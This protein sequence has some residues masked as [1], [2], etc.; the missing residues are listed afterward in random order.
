LAL[1][2]VVR[3]YYSERSFRGD[4]CASNPEFDSRDD[5]TFE[6]PGSR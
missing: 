1:L 6:I 2:P 4:A 5:L 3:L